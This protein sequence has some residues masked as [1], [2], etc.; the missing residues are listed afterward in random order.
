MAEWDWERNNEL[1]IFPY[2]VSCGSHKEIWWICEKGHRWMAIASN[3]ARLGRGC[4]YCAGQKPVVGENDLSTTHSELVKEWHLTKNGEITP[5]QYMGGS[6]KKVWWMCEEGHEWYAEIKS[7]ASGVGCPYCAGKKVMYGFNDLETKYPELAKEWHPT[8]NGQLTPAQVTYGS[9]KKVWWMCKNGHEWITDVS[10]RTVGRGCP[11]CASRRRTSFPEQ[12]I[13]YYVKQAF[14]DAINGYKEAFG[15][16]SMELDVFIPQI[17][18]GI[19]YDGKAFHA[20][21]HNRLRDAKKYS[22]CK[23]KGIMLVRITDNPHYE[24]MTNC[25]HKITIP[26][27]DDYYL[28]YAITELLFKLRKPTNVNVA[29]NRLSI[30]KYLT[31]FD[32]SLEEKFPELAIEWNYDKNGFPPSNIHPGSNQRVWWLCKKC[33]CEWKTSP[34]ERTGRDKTGCPIC[35]KIE[36]G[37]KRSATTLK[38]RGSVAEKA[39]FLLDEWDYE[40]NKISPEEIACTSGENVWW[41]CRECGY[42]WQTTIAHRATRRSGCPCCKNRV[43]VQGINDLPTTHPNL[44]EEWNLEKNSIQPTEI[45]VGS[46]KKAWWKCTQCGYE[47]LAVIN[48]RKKRGCPHC[49]RQKRNNKNET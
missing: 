24:I 30:L 32:D 21:V 14:P 35:A 4:P 45:S 22:M 29:A 46:G 15:K 13:F 37:K 38:I 25:D 44:I 42:N 17:N 12:A 10:N 49:A 2:S 33:G 41:K 43:V 34:A 39:V 8:K 26:K 27:A 11:V 18:V 3:R 40:K 23:E 36:G 20:E 16:G 6:H 1:N 9:G 28:T 31:A 7:R 47:W 5:E 19:E 48:T